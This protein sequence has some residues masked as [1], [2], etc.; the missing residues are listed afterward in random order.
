[1]AETAQKKGHLMVRNA[2]WVRVRQTL[3]SALQSAMVEPEL[4]GSRRGSLAKSWDCIL[5]GCGG[6]DGRAFARGLRSQSRSRRAAVLGSSSRAAASQRAALAWSSGTIFRSVTRRA[7]N[8]SKSNRRVAAAAQET[9]LPGSAHQLTAVLE[10][11][12]DAIWGQAAFCS[13][14]SA[15]AYAR[16][17]FAAIRPSF[18]ESHHASFCL[19]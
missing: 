2:L 18:R 7:T 10:P 1:M 16:I 12:A 17:A 15:P 19:S 3:A 9:I 14:A 4:E 11:K 5:H 13:H 6:V 8:G